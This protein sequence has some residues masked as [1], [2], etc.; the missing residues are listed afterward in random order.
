MTPL[1]KH[2]LEV[3][4]NAIQVQAE[5]AR[6]EAHQEDGQ[7]RKAE[8]IAIAE[9]HEALAA[10][11]TALAQAEPPIV[12]LAKSSP[13]LYAWLHTC[14][15]EELAAV[16]MASGEDDPV[17][18]LKGKREEW[19]KMFREGLIGDCTTQPITCMRCLAEKF[20]KKVD[21]LR[22]AVTP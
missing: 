22:A 9:A 17:L 1:S 11:L 14:P 15:W 8:F 10:N 5:H 6:Y 13:A 20:K 21:A 18:W 7:R 3:C 4:A 2:D 19:P 16:L 12:H